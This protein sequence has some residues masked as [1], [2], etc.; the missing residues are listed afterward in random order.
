MR[1]LHQL[2]TATALAAVGAA[3][4]YGDN[5]V[6]NTLT[7]VIDGTAFTATNVAAAHTGNTL[8][9]T[10]TAAS[11]QIVLTVPNVTSTG[12]FSLAAGQGSTGQVLVAP[13]GWTTAATGGTGSVTIT[14]YS[15]TA[16][17]GTFTFSAPAGTGG[18]AG[19]KV[20]TAGSFTVY[21]GSGGGP[22]Y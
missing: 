11:Q 19:T 22:I 14:A 8:S 15:S 3:C 12:T 17:T 4:G 10:A 2:L 13:Q 1:K 18:A 6:T 7:A 9:I 20:V 21:Y 16:A 5:N